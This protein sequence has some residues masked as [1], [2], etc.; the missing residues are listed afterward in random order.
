MVQGSQVP[1]QARSCKPSPRTHSDYKQANPERAAAEATA[2]KANVERAAAAGTQDE[3]EESTAK[4]VR[5]LAPDPTPPP[6]EPRPA[7]QS[8]QHA[9]RR[10][11]GGGHLVGLKHLLHPGPHARQR[12]PGRPATS[13]P[14]RATCMAEVGEAGRRTLEDVEEVIRLLVKPPLARLSPPP[15]LSLT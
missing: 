7:L 1:A 11:R 9:R 6:M 4:D 13:S 8:Y 14:P 3:D 2:E 15:L 5:N 12:S 10:W